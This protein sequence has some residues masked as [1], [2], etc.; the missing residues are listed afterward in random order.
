MNSYNSHKHVLNGS[1]YMSLDVL[2]LAVIHLSAYERLQ[3]KYQKKLREA[4]LL[5][6]DVKKSHA[7]LDVILQSVNTLKVLASLDRGSLSSFETSL[8]N[9]TVVIMPFLA[10]GRGAGHSAVLNRIV[11]LRA[12]FWSFYRIFKHIVVFVRSREDADY[13]STHSGLPFLEVVVLHHLPKFAA[14]PV[15]SV[16]TTQDFLRNGTWDFDFVFFTESDQILIM[17]ELQTYYL[18]LFRHARHMIVPHRLMPYPEI[19]SHQLTLIGM[20]FLTAL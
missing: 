7:S 17:R 10:S 6:K 18:H 16:Q 3:R 2:D 1:V 15:G 13:V 11:Y 4:R 5:E 12:C 14:L 8:A 9:R 19:V 20:H